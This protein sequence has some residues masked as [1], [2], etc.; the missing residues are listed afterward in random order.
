[1]KKNILITG[2]TDG[3]GLEAAKLIVKSNHNVLIHGRNEA[4]LTQAKDEVLKFNS[5]AE[6]KT[7]CADLSNLSALPEFIE[8]IKCSVQN[9]DVLINNAGVFKAQ[10]TMTSEGLDVRFSVNTIA[11]YILTKALLPAMNTGGRII[12]VSSA[13]QAP[14]SLDALKG[15]RSLSDSEAYAQSKLAITMWTFHMANNL[16]STKPSMIA[17]NPASFLG[18]KMV[19]EAYGTAGKDIGIGANILLKAALANEFNNMTGRYF[20]NDIGNWASPHSDALDKNK[21][22]LL[23]EAMHNVI[24][25]LQIDS[26]GFSIL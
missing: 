24:K 15:L 19:K 22:R 11:P 26:P 13:A 10:K 1:M 2:S 16:G 20:D 9:I 17:V 6:V 4:K 14:V 12:N 21:N 8:K 23:V 5:A 3:I 25:D 7:L 18:S